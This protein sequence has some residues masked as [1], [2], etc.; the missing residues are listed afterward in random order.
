V[1]IIIVGAEVGW[2]VTVGEVAGV[3]GAVRVVVGRSW[4]QAARR[5]V[6]RMRGR[7]FIRPLF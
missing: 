4:V 7:C 3:G 5:M 1:E 6:R 2:R